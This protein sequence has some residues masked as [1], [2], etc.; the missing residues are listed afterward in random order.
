MRYSNKKIPRILVLVMF[1]VS[2]PLTYLYKPIISHVE[3][4]S[5]LSLTP[6]ADAFVRE[7]VPN[8]NYGSWNDIT[9]GRSW[10]LGNYFSEAFGY[11]KFD[12]SSL[13]NQSIIY[14]ATL[15]FYQYVRSDNA[16]GNYTVRIA[17]ANSSW[18]ELGITWN[19]R[20]AFTGVYAE[21]SID[22]FASQWFNPPKKYSFDV[23]NLVKELVTGGN[24]GL[25]IYKE[26]GNAGGFWCSRNYNNATCFASSVPRLTVSYS[27][28]TAPN[29]PH[30]T[31]PA[32][33]EEFGGDSTGQ[34]AQVTLKVDGLGDGDG[35]LDGTWFYYKR[36]QDSTWQ[37]SPKRTGQQT[38]QY[39]QFL[40]DGMWEWRARSLDTMGLWSNYSPTWT[41]TIDTTPPSQPV[42]EPEP[43]YTAGDQNTI[44]ST[45][46]VDE[47][48]G[49]V[50][51]LFNVH[52]G[53]DCA[54]AHFQSLWQQAPDITV[55]NLQH[56]ETYCYQV[57]A[58]DKLGNETAWSDFIISTQDAVF[59]EVVSVS[60][61]DLVFSP[62]GDGQFD[63]TVFSFEILEDHFKQWSIL[64][65]NFTG[66]VVKSI[67]GSDL[68][69]AVVW[70]GEDDGG[71]VVPDGPYTFELEAEDL[72]GNKTVNGSQVVSIDNTE[73][74]LNISLPINGA[75]FNTET[76]TI[77]GITE[78]NAQL[79]ANGELQTVDENGIFEFEASL[80]DGKNEFT[81]MA[82][83]IVGNSGSIV[84][85]VKK[86]NNM[87]VITRILP[88]SLINTGQ[89]TINIVLSDGESG[90]DKES[91]YL[92]ITDSEG[93][94]L[95]LVN[96]G[97]NIQPG[98]GHIE[99]D[100][101]SETTGGS[102][103][104]N[105]SYVLD[106]PLQPDGVY[107]IQSNVSDVAGNKSNDYIQEFELD[108]H[109]YLNATAPLDGA[110][111]N[112]S[113]IVIAGTAEQN[114]MLNVKSTMSNVSLNI[115]PSSDE[116]TNCRS[117]DDTFGVGWE[118]IKQVCDFEILDFQ[119][120]ADYLNDV[121]VLN[122]IDFELT[123][124]AG[125]VIK[126]QRNVQVNLFA[127]ELSIEG[128]LEFISPNGDGRQDGIDFA[129]KAVNRENRSEDVDV[130]EWRITINNSDNLITRELSGNNHLPA[131]YYFDGREEGG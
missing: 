79:T 109:T 40:P 38:A 11:I 22:G 41:F 90:I 111:L 66:I 126:D 57:K 124:S 52:R 50:V 55:G 110:L 101:V 116:V 15:D 39:T 48:I 118:G 84:L 100:C 104:C 30:P 60:V 122:S 42:P 13:N 83:D 106:G 18:S 65:K 68:S 70:S 91:V 81:I 1:L 130:D 45:E 20:P 98:L 6:I 25:V 56:E 37:T 88:N 2:S 29:I 33:L 107:T 87:P 64:I 62:N 72:A 21:Q 117:A 80:V 93:N 14:S 5:T 76:V 92:S 105:Y 27:Q 131:N 35:N 7:N 9:I 119:L 10:N 51:Y 24:N 115:S 67:T 32:N 28:N 36:V 46:S 43:E 3:A 86:E 120:E 23:T 63:S 26:L 128:N 8:T 47:I 77:A 97:Q 82:V 123:D 112:K 127:I 95:V 129:L 12:L 44:I 19:N 17:K 75:W 4:A 31:S 113:K 114:S 73:A 69:H 53:Q 125:N 108:S 103:I 58:K 85:T 59:P 94:E 71:S 61:S 34:G 121:E 74:T 99:T 78:P 96:D 16:S 54:T 89:L 102:L 49:E